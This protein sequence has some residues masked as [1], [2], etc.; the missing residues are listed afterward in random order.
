MVFA[1]LSE[2]VQLSFFVSYW[3]IREAFPNLSEKRCFF[4]A[5]PRPTKEAA[6]LVKRPP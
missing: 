3:W 5:C 2:S 4:R 1:G 6:A